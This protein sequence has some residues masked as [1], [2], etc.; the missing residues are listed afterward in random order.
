MQS[1]QIFGVIMLI[2]IIFILI[3]ALVG[4]IKKSNDIGDIEYDKIPQ[5]KFTAFKLDENDK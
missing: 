1:L 4:K 5:E 2:I 3:S